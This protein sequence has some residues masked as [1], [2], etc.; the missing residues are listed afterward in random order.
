ML[1]VGLAALIAAPMP[2]HA[3]LVVDRLIVDFMPGDPPR[4]DILLQNQSKD[5]YYITITPAEVLKPGD[6]KPTEVT[7]TN[8]E[9]LGLL[10]TPNRMILDPGASR[11]IRVVSLNSG[12]S[13]DRIYRVMIEPQIGDMPNEEGAD[14]TVALKILTAYDAL[15]IVRPSKPKPDLVAARTVT[16]LVL[17]NNGNSNTLVFDGLACPAAAPAA[18]AKPA[19][20]KIGAHR[21]YAGASWRVPLPHPDDPVTFQVQM[22]DASDPQTI[23]Y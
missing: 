13:T 3:Q 23:K 11:S 21:M 20:A 17:T 9:E 16:G 8:P 6:D 14:R 1:G 10:V 4:E 12:L 5:R 18:G 22:G 15:V 19:C 7:K 2:A